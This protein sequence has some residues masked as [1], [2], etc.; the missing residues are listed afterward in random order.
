MDRVPASNRS[1]TPEPSLDS[2]TAALRRIL[3]SD[4]V[5]LAAQEA[6]R[7]CARALE[8]ARLLVYRVHPYGPN[9]TLVL[10]PDRAF[11]PGAP[12]GNERVDSV[13][14]EL[15]ARA[16]MLVQGAPLVFT[17]DAIDSNEDQV[18]SALAIPVVVENRL[19]SVVACVSEVD[20]DRW[21]G[22]T[23]ALCQ[24]AAEAMAISTL[25]SMAQRHDRLEAAL[26][27]S[28]DIISVVSPDGAILSYTPNASRVF[29]G[30]LQNL[31]KDDPESPIH[32]QDRPRVARAFSEILK[33]PGGQR[34]IEIRLRHAD[35]SWLLYEAVGTNQ[36][37]NPLIRGIV[38]TA[39]DITERK[40]LEDRLHWQ[41]LHD[42]LTKLAN[43]ALLLNDLR[44]ALARSERSGE[45]IGILYLDLDGFKD[46]NDHFGHSTG[47]Q[48]LVKIGERLS[49]SVRAGETVARLGG[50]EFIILLEGLTSLNDAERAAVRVLDA[51]RIPVPLASGTVTITASL[52]ISI[53]SNQTVDPDDLLVRADTALY[54]AKRAGRNQFQTNGAE[55]LQGKFSF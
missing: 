27:Y 20:I 50:D 47:D 36:V 19:I 8:H 41:A 52:G 15:E 1:N 16:D 18:R 35:G 55:T 53:A 38:V 40:L 21:S 46:I 54:A 10:E 28:T 23:G 51:I 5:L 33:S 29:G 26:T 42:P 44:R 49:A 9:D 13:R 3:A 6:L 45:K 31:A 24:V 14:H 34:R 22:D 11:T 7:I 17:V 48:M 43:R 4:D 30:S 2:A 39:H 37:E 12:L 25:R 32:P